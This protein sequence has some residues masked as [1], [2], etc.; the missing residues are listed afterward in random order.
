MRRT[1]LEIELDE[2]VDIKNPIEQ[3]KKKQHILDNFINLKPCPFCG[4]E[5]EVVGVKKD[6]TTQNVWY[7]IKHE[8]C[9]ATMASNDK[10]H[11]TEQWN[12]RA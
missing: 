2:M 3:Q 8:D 5:V 7:A 11:L 9:G 12:K 4:K 1:R 6:P 10:D